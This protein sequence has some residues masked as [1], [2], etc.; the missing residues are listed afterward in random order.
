VHTV[1]LGLASDARGAAIAAGADGTLLVAGADGGAAGPSAVVVRI[2][3]DGRVD[4]GFGS[5][6]VVRLPSRS[7][8]VAAGARDVAEIG[9][10]IFVALADLGVAR[11]LSDGSPDPRFSGDGVADAGPREYASAVGIVGSPHGG[12]T[13]IGQ[14]RRSFAETGVTEFGSVALHLLPDG[15]SASPPSEQLGVYATG[16]ARRDGAGAEIAGF[17][18]CGFS[19]RSSRDSPCGGSLLRTSGSGALLSPFPRPPTSLEPHV[20]RYGAIV[21]QSD[22]GTLTFGG[23]QDGRVLSRRYGAQGR[24][25][26]AFGAC[27]TRV[28]PSQ[29]TPVAGVESG[30]GGVIIAGTRTGASPVVTKWT[31]RASRTGRYGEELS[32]VRSVERGIDAVRRAGL[33]VRLRFSRS[34]TVRVRLVATR[35]AGRVAGLRG[36][37]AHRVV[38]VSP[39]RRASARLRVGREDARLIRGLERRGIPAYVVRWS[40]DRR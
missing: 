5:D 1:A 10:R 24:P 3:R 20:R 25:R 18:P 13:V 37:L 35:R 40:A 22:G 19:V 23:L 8:S 7:G 29:L 11:L 17:R 12:A 2:G 26:E 15:T 31:E 6:G 33:P 30:D 39:C 4:R 14:F 16:I 38:R 21:A 27:G 32:T 34:A 36:T 28:G 9:G